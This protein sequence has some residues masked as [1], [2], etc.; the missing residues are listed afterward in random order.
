MFQPYLPF[1]GELKVQGGLILYTTIAQS[2]Y[3]SQA[4]QGSSWHNKCSER[5]KRIVCWPRLTKE[6]TDLIESCDTRQRENKRER[7]NAT[8]WVP[9]K[10]RIYSRNRPVPNKGPSVFSH[11]GLFFMSF[12]E[13]AK[14]TSTT[15]EA[16]IKHFKSIFARQG[17]QKGCEWTMVCSLHQNCSGSSHRIGS[18]ATSPPVRTSHKAMGRQKEP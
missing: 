3:I 12:F 1:Q 9:T 7:N 13:V 10:A 17:Y 8:H 16:V 15:S 5:A 18:L 11:C 4:A 2:R 14:L 6:L